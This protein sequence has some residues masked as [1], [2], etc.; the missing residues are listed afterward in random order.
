METTNSVP[1]SNP[2]NWE[3][4]NGPIQREPEDEPPKK[5]DEFDDA[6]KP[7]KREIFL[8]I[9]IGLLV[10]A[11]II[12]VYFVMANYH[13]NG[14]GQ[15]CDINGTC[16]IG[17]NQSG[18]SVT[19]TNTTTN[20]TTNTTSKLAGPSYAY[21]KSQTEGEFMESNISILCQKGGYTDTVRDV[22]QSIRDRV[23]KDYGYNKTL[24]ESA[25][26]D[27]FIPLCL[28]GSNNIKNLWVEYENPKPGYKEK[29]KLEAYLCRAVCDGRIN[30]SDA[31]MMMWNDWVDAYNKMEGITR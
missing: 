6:K 30:L 23:Y 1:I 5:Y 29:D 14:I 16:L 15:S 21:P 25:E 22:P 12:A 18:I 8:Y 28:G 13:P 7:S 3:E 17:G 9:L 19:T 2:A 26:L 20:P 31:Q 11:A 27:H 10:I 24:N 4:P